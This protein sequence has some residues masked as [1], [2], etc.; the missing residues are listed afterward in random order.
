M[1]ESE[2]QKP[3]AQAQDAVAAYPPILA[4]GTKMLYL[5][6]YDTLDEAVRK[7]N[8]NFLAGGYYELEGY[9]LFDRYR[10]VDEV[11]FFDVAGRELEPV[12]DPK[13]GPTSEKDDG[14]RL[15][16]LAVKNDTPYVRSRFRAMLQE[17]RPEIE[18]GREEGKMVPPVVDDSQGALP[19]KDFSFEELCQQ[20]AHVLAND[21]ASGWLHKVFGGH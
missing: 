17:V 6:A 11:R 5:R 10:L 13:R 18:K 19:D 14:Y 9:H 15:S 20:L 2:T 21:Y 3:Q 8:E 12:W 1:Q 4:V 16:T 7:I